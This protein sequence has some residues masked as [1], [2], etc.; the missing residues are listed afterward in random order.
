MNDFGYAVEVTG[1]SPKATE[2]DVYDFFAFSGAIQHVEIVRSGDYACTA[3]V[4]FE[5]AYSQETALLLSG[6]TI[7][8]QRVCITRW[9][10]CEEEFHFWNPSRSHEDETSSSQPPLGSQ[11]ASHAGEAVSFAQ[12]VVKAML[13][14]GYV[15]GKD[16]LTKA[17]AFDESHQVSATAATKVAELSERI[18]LTDKFCASVEAVRSVDQRYHVSENTKSAISTAGRTAA[19]AAN[20]V[21]SSSYFSRGALWVSGALDRAAKAAADLGN[22]GVHQ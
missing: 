12:D 15:L 9:G 21:I 8:D 17:K 11:F 10:Q 19:A 16:A 5:N 14:K 18:G 20:T 3:Y 4:T 7:L 6:A 22:R 2:K 1:L 13:A